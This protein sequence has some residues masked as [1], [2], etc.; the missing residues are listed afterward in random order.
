MRGRRPWALE[1]QPRNWLAVCKE[2]KWTRGCTPSDSDASVEV[3]P[4]MDGMEAD[5]RIHRPGRPWPNARTLLACVR[6][7]RCVLYARRGACWETAQLSE[8]PRFL[9]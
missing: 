1:A 3:R 9:E 8:E 2:S 7:A 4:P 5:R 6:V